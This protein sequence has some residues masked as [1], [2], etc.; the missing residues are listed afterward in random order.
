MTV[1]ATSVILALIVVFKRSVPLTQRAWNCA[2]S[3]ESLS[4]CDWKS[5]AGLWT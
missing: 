2:I 1:C 4:L 3:E 5:D